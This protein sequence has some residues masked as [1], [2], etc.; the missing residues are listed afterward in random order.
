[1][2]NKLNIIACVACFGCILSWGCDRNSSKKNAANGG[3]GS[4]T[5]VEIV[6]ASDAKCKNEEVNDF[7][8]KALTVCAEGDY[9]EYRLLWSL[10]HQPTNRKRF[11]QL[12]DATKQV[13]VKTIRRLQ[14]RLPD[15]S[16]KVLDTPVYV[17]HA[18]VALKE[19]AKQ[20]SERLKDRD[21]ILQ[22]VRRNN[23][24]CFI[25]AAK[26]VK[27]SVLADHSSGPPA[28]QPA[29]PPNGVPTQPTPSSGND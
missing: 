18:F 10:D 5:A 23:A 4:D 27:E 1:M 22:I 26:E 25:P 6:W 2:R 17:L 20:R 28:A 21:L 19:E 16:M 24:W 12:R 11:M 29:A 8:A 15:G 9:A 14:F 7:V 3:L 13:R